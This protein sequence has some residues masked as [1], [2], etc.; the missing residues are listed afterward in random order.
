MF[1]LTIFPGNCEIETKAWNC[2][3]IHY[4]TLNMDQGTSGGDRHPSEY[5]YR[6]GRKRIHNKRLQGQPQYKF[7]LWMAHCLLPLDPLSI[8]RAHCAALCLVMDHIP[9]A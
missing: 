3:L 7:L 6:R 1:C 5:A 9:T 2:I 8:S 4:A